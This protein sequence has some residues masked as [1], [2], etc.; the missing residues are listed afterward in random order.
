MLFS[1][2]FCLELRQSTDY[3][4]DVFDALVAKLTE[5][6]THQNLRFLRLPHPRTG[7]T[8][9]FMVVLVPA[10]QGSGVPSLF[11]PYAKPDGRT[12]IMEVQ[13]VAPPNERSW[14]LSE[15]QVVQSAC[16]RQSSPSSAHSFL[17]D[18][19]LLIMTPVDPAFL[20][21]PILHVLSSV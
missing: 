21:I 4:P 8:Y 1:Y 15:G 20:L 11:L 6:G 16:L 13:T 17:P 9:V 19:E 18:G 14:F 7:K 5:A 2:F 3:L 12:S 10:Q